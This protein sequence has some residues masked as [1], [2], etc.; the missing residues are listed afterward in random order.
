[1]MRLP[2]R[3]LALLGLC[4]TFSDCRAVDQVRAWSQTIDATE[5]RD[6]T[7]SVNG[8]R[9]VGRCVVL[10]DASLPIR[11]E[12]AIDE[13][14]HQLEFSGD[15]ETIDGNTCHAIAD[16]ERTIVVRT[17]PKRVTLRLQ[18]TGPGTLR[19]LGGECGPDATCAIEL[20]VDDLVTV[21]AV[22]SRPNVRVNWSMPGCSGLTCSLQATS[23]LTLGARFEALVAVR[24][25]AGSGG[26]VW[27]NGT[28]VVGAYESLL[29]AG[30][31]VRIRAVPDADH[32][33]GRFAGLP[34]RPVRSLEA[35]EFDASADVD[36]SVEFQR[37]FQWGLGAMSTTVTDVVARS[38][39]DALVFGH[40]RRA[41]LGLPA[42]LGLQS[43]VL[44]LHPDAGFGRVS[45]SDLGL[46]TS[47]FLVGS[48]G[49]LWLSGG[50]T[51]QAMAGGLNFSWGNIDG[52]SSGPPTQEADRALLRFDESVFAPV[53]ATVFDLPVSNGVSALG[54]GPVIATAEGDL[55]AFSLRNHFD[56]GSYPYFTSVAR[57]DGALNLVGLQPVPSVT[58]IDVLPFAS[59]PVG[60]GMSFPPTGNTPGCVVTSADAVPFLFYVAASGTCTAVTPLADAGSTVG[61]SELGRGLPEP[62]FLSVTNRLLPLRGPGTA[63]STNFAHVHSHDLALS[64]RWRATL[65]P[66]IAT[67]PSQGAT[68]LVPVSVQEWSGHVLAFFGGY[69]SGVSGYRAQGGLTIPCDSRADSRLL[70]TL[71][72]R[73]SG[74]LLW[75]AC[76]LEGPTDAGVRP[77]RAVLRQDVGGYNQEPSIIKAF[78]GILV[79]PWADGPS[80]SSLEFGFGSQRITL[81]GDS[82]WLGLLQPPSLR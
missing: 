23:N 63:I 45:V 40:F 9:C 22:A 69:G 79:A 26:D 1:M 41:A 12:A 4:L 32:S 77:W 72:D 49:G 25:N 60:L 75:G 66:V 56:G 42:P 31:A 14:T 19:V 10:I 71:H 6:A 68:N 20:P 55:T 81:Q 44:E 61:V 16:R 37:L 53:S 38:G 3:Q 21:E 11:V 74:E 39:G 35:C 33:V 73:N 76:I 50:I 34:C 46:R 36:G 13:R 15:C 18:T 62:L 29:P 80:P 58:P 65:E 28:A 59:G 51:Y 30:E 82:S 17:Q 52:G 70:I 64:E 48:D 24:V 67:A 43:F 8:E 57:V 7:V 78:G 54:R 27:V 5:A 2:R 47:N